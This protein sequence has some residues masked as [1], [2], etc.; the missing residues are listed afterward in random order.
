VSGGDHNRVLGVL[1]GAG[2]VL[3]AVLFAPIGL[4][5]LLLLGVRELISRLR[6]D[7]RP[8]IPA[9]PLDSDDF[10]DAAA[11]AAALVRELKAAVPDATETVPDP[12]YW[13]P[14][15]HDDMTLPEAMALTSPR[16]RG[17]QV[18]VTW[19][20]GEDDLVRVEFPPLRSN[21][22]A[23]DWHLGDPVSEVY[24]IAAGMLA[25]GVRY[26]P[27]KTGLNRAWIRVAEAD[28]WTTLGV[29]AAKSTFEPD[30]YRQLPDD[31][32]D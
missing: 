19:A 27:T 23:H 11:G 21:V 25:N 10:D 14:D 18:L 20:P 22:G 5:A 31:F 1:K 17:E 2:W 9:C 8:V 15:E 13:P 32:Q 4:V 28:G 16:M 7:Y 6:G 29:T 12:G 30:W 26:G 24:W 3:L